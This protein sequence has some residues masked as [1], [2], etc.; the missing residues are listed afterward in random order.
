MGPEH[1]VIP[2]WLPDLLLNLFAGSWWPISHCCLYF[3]AIAVQCVSVWFSIGH[4]SID[5]KL[6]H[7][8]RSENLFFWAIYFKILDL[9]EEFYSTT[10]SPH[11]QSPNPQPSPPFPSPSCPSPPCPSPLT[12]LPLNPHPSPSPHLTFPPPFLSACPPYI[13][14]TAHWTMHTVTEYNYELQII[15]SLLVWSWI[16]KKG[17]WQC[18]ATA[19]AV[20]LQDSFMCCGFRFPWPWPCLPGL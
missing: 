19:L 17:S 12:P 7:A 15:H 11:L 5:L 6:N 8:E 18:N 13:L 2:T 3:I 1:D 20:D 16:R 14:P 9:P 10:L 4:V